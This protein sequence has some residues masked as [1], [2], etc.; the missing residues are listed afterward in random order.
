MAKAARWRKQ[1]RETGLRSIGQAPRGYELRLDGD[2]L[3]WVSPA[4]G[5]ALNGP[6]RG[7]YWC[8]F[9]RNTYREGK[10]WATAEE[11][12]EDCTAA[13]KAQQQSAEDSSK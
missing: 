5:G 6:V 4:G 10:M 12:R 8:G 1:P 3:A 11:A 2:V 9:D 13:Y 7:W